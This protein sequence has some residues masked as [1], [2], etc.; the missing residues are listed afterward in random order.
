MG[1]VGRGR[2]AG[3]R[4]AWGY[5][6]VPFEQCESVK[7]AHETAMRLAKSRIPIYIAGESGAGRRTLARSVARAVPGASEFVELSANHFDPVLLSPPHRRTRVVIAEFPELL[8]AK[9]QVALAIAADA[10]AVRLVAWGAEAAADKLDPELRYLLEPGWVLLPPLRD[11]GSDVLKWA[12]FFLHRLRA[13]AAP[14]LSAGAEQALLH[15]RWP[16]NLRQL[17]AALRRAVLRREPGDRSPITAEELVQP[18]QEEV[19]PL[20]QAVER[21]RQSYVLD[22]LARFDGDRVRTAQAL[23]VDPGSLS[24]LDD[25]RKPN[26]T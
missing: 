8:D 15:N 11:R 26:A 19:L 5:T 1:I 6:N 4:S 25:P 10:R 22:M 12:V 3:A 20:A 13:D 17:D 2:Q 7:R 16:G 23:G 14:R 9:R 24:G 21:F 18:A